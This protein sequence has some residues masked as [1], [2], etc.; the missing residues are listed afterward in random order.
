MFWFSPRS[1]FRKSLHGLLLQLN[2]RLP[3]EVTDQIANGLYVIYSKNVQINKAIGA[4]SKQKDMHLMWDLIQYEAFFLKDLLSES[5]QP[6]HKDG[7]EN[8][9]SILKE[10]NIKMPNLR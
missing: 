4:K 9:I 10:Y 3:I 7:H 1:L 2:V 6:I 8:T 5:F